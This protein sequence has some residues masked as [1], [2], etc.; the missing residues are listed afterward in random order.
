MRRRR[1]I[2]TALLSDGPAYAGWLASEGLS[3]NYYKK[4]AEDKLNGWA[5]IEVEVEL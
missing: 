4:L 1:V 2:P 3:P 5:L